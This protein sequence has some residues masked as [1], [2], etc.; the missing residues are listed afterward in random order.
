MEFYKYIDEILVVQSVDEVNELLSNGYAL[1]NSYTTT[2][3]TG[4][5]HETLNY[6]LGRINMMRKFPERKD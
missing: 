4:D 6:S 2:G 3:Y 1:I 5:N